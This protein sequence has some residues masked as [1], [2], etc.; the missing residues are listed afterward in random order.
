MHDLVFLPDDPATNISAS[1]I[2][3]TLCH[4]DFL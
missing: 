3:I 4:I 2:V 1:Q